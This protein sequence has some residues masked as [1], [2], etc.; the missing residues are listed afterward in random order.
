MYRSCNYLSFVI[1][2]IRLQSHLAERHWV[3]VNSRVNYPIIKEALRWMEQQQLIDM[4]CLTT[5]YCVSLM[6]GKMCQV[7]IQNHISTW[8]N[9]R[10]PG[11]YNALLL[12]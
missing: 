4:D 3:E 10:I 1:L 2:C 7:G 5:K 12:S 9:H 11:I 6:V 8:N